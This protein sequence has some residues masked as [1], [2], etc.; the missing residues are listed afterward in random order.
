[1]QKK[2][3]PL[4]SCRDY[5]EILSSKGLLQTT[6]L[7]KANFSQTM[8][9]TYTKNLLSIKA[10]E[11]KENKIFITSYGRFLLNELNKVIISYNLMMKEIFGKASQG[12]G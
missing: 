6:I 11:I 1:M 2:R 4:E 8:Y 9:K 7:L 12:S 10:I 5:L 3:N